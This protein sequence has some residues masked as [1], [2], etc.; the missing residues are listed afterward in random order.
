MPASDVIARKA[1]TNIHAPTSPRG[2]EDIGRN[3][4]KTSISDSQGLECCVATSSWERTAGITPETDVAGTVHT[5]SSTESQQYRAYV[6]V[7][8]ACLQQYGGWMSHNMGVND[9][10]VSNGEHAWLAQC[11]GHYEMQSSD[12]GT[13]NGNTHYAR[14]QPPHLQ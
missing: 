7:P 4:K 11:I 2:T 10:W 5:S 6:L 8:P 1:S 3:D 9:R 13:P 12:S 14:A